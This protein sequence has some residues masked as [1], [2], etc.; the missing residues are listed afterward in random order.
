[1]R[2]GR[3]PVGAF[4]ATLQRSLFHPGSFF[5]GTAPHR[6]AGAA[7]LYAVTVGTLSIAVALLWEH[8]LGQR[9]AGQFGGRHFDLAGRGPL[10]AAFSLLLP[11]GIAISSIAWAGVLHVSLAVLGGAKGGYGATLKAVCYSSS[12]AAFNV[13]PI[14]GAAIGFVWQTVAQVIGLRE[15]HRTSTA[16]AFWALLL[17][18]AIAI[19]L[20]GALFFA[21]VLGMAKVMLEFG[22]GKFSV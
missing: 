7:L 9:L 13:F 21:I 8:A 1:V 4:A 18:L 20:A 3:G 19:C 17:P 12:A 5:R 2:A 10:L 22:G 15:L 11:V 14:C 6:G 16:R